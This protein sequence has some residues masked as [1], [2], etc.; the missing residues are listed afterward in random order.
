MFGFSSVLFTQQADVRDLNRFDLADFANATRALGG[1]DRVVL[2]ETQN[3]RVA[4]FGGNGDD[5]ITGSGQA[6]DIRGGNGGDDLRGRARDDELAGGSGNDVLAGGMGDDTLVGGLGRDTLA[7]ARGDDALAAGTRD[8]M[9]IGGTGRDTLAGGWGDDALAGGIGAD[10]L[11]GG[12]GDDRFDFDSTT[13]STFGAGRDLIRMF[14]NVGRAAGDRIDLL[15]IDARAGG[16][17][18][19]FDF[20]GTAGFSARGQLRVFNQGGDTVIAGN[21]TGDVVSDFQI[22]VDDGSV[23]AS[24]WRAADFLL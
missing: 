19:P 7:G 8:D 18:T 5:S 15:D 23:G 24:D 21:T 10:T 6:D 12:L 9:L 2:S 20:I 22:L 17:D 14:D 4:F 16:P 13:D 11:I 1:N 3:I